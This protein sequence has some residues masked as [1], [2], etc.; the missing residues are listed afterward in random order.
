MQRLENVLRLC[1]V[2]KNDIL[3]LHIKWREPLIAGA[4][5]YEIH[6]Q[7]IHIKKMPEDEFSFEEDCEQI[8]LEIAELVNAVGHNIKKNSPDPDCN[9]KVDYFIVNIGNNME[10]AKK[11]KNVKQWMSHR[12]LYIHWRVI[13]DLKTIW[14]KVN[15]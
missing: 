9:C 6:L 10:R 13:Y 7:L 1:L 3:L 11:Y 4:V 8:E 5:K 14:L 15:C 2:L 12:E